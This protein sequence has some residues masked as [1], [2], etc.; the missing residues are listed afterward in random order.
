V[1]AG[2]NHHALAAAEAE[3]EVSRVKATPR[4]QGEEEVVLEDS[5]G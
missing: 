2:S 3:E 5:I 4:G 1:R